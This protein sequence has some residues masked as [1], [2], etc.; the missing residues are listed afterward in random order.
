MLF[1]LYTLGSV[2]LGI[3]AVALCKLLKG[4]GT[5]VVLREC[6]DCVAD[7]AEFL[8]EELNQLNQNR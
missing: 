1:T 8:E 4:V 2:A 7:A 6:T 3:I 5:K